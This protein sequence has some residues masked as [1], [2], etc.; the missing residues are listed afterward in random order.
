M[1]QNLGQQRRESCVVDLLARNAYP[2]VE[3]HQMRA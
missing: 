3:T 1:V 2:F